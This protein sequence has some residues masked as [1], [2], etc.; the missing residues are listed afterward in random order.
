LGL[1]A[2][3]RGGGPLRKVLDEVWIAFRT[4][5]DL[6]LNS[7]AGQSFCYHTSGP[8]AG[9]LDLET[10]HLPGFFILNFSAPSAVKL[11][12]SVVGVAL[13]YVLYAAGSI[14]RATA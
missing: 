2:A 9:I 7:V 11:G 10:L 12:L 14:G 4:C 3:T 6:P 5:D 8:R 13:G 1:C